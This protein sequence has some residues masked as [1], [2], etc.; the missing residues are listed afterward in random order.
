MQNGKT[1]PW[2]IGNKD[3]EANMTDSLKFPYYGE[4]YDTNL[5]PVIGSEI[6]KTR[7]SLIVSNNTGNE[8]SATVTILPITSQTAKKAY[9]FEVSIPKGTAGLTEES[10]IK[11]NQI[12]TID[13]KRLDRY[14]GTLPAS[15]YP[16]IEQ[17]MKVHLNMK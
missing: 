1:L 16:Q 7:P 12:R 4:I 8:F 14:R 2:K 13:K 10:R 3:I 9:L 15:Y 6:G 5:E 17:A 11:A